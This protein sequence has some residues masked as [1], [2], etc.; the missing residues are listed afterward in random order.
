MER[1]EVELPSIFSESWTM[2]LALLYLTEA[3]SVGDETAFS[4]TLVEGLEETAKKAPFC[5][6]AE[7]ERFKQYLTVY[8]Y[9]RLRQ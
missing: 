3:S 6:S 8:L 7:G 1:I 9:Y 4:E 5:S 2:L